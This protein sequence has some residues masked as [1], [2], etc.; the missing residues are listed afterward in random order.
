[1]KS[2]KEITEI[3]VKVY[4]ERFM[5]NKKV[6][7]KRSLYNPSERHSYRLLSSSL[8]NKAVSMFLSLTNKTPEQL[9]QLTYRKINMTL[10]Y[11]LAI[12]PENS[13]ALLNRS[14]L[15]WRMGVLRDDQFQTII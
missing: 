7:I 6:Y 14:L 8:N 10:K 15:N 4:A 9:K 11:A 12:S 1:M 5:K 3:A 2:F 13:I